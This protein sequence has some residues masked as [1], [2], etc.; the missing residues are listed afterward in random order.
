M[1]E[2]LRDNL[3][4]IAVATVLLLVLICAFLKILKDKKNGKGCCGSGCSECACAG[5]CVKEN[6]ADNK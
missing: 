5:M 4:T 1:F 6:K 2:F 3:G